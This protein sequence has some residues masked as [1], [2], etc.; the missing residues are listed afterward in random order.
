MSVLFHTE[1]KAAFLSTLRNRGTRK[2][3][4][5][6]AS[7]LRYAGGKSLAVGLIVELL[8]DGVKGVAS[9]FMDVGHVP[10]RGTLYQN[11]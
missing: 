9:P 1:R 6:P 8:P 11:G 3:R 4:R 5:Y 10:F 2:Y 7:P